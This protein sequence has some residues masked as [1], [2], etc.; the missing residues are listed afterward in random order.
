MDSFLKQEL[1]DRLAESEANIATG[2][3]NISRRREHVAE[4]ERTGQDAELSR[5]VLT[6]FEDCQATR[7]EE[8]GHLVR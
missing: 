5:S 4:L 2:A 8:L 7:R 6:S 3:S 1:L